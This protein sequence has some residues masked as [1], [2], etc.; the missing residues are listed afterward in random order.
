MEENISLYNSFEL[1]QYYYWWIKKT[2]HN[3]EK[4]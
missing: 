2:K 1:T 4:A 3:K